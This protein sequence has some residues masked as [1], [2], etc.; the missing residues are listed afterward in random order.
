MNA[1]YSNAQKWFLGSTL[2]LVVFGELAYVLDSC[3]D[4]WMNE[5]KAL[6]PEAVISSMFL[7]KHLL[8]LILSIAVG[9]LLFTLIHYWKKR[10]AYPKRLSMVLGILLLLLNLF[11]W[12]AIYC[13]SEFDRD[14][15]PQDMD[16]HAELRYIRSKSHWFGRGDHYY[17]YPDTS[18]RPD[19]TVEEYQQMR[20]VSIRETEKAYYVFGQRSASLLPYL[21][22][23]YGKWVSGLY[24]LVA[25][26]W[27][28]GAVIGWKAVKGIWNRVLYGSCFLVLTAQVVGPLLEQLGI[29]IWPMPI[30]FSSMD[31]SYHI[32]C[33]VPLFA[34]MAFLVEGQAINE[35]PQSA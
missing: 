29:L 8:L 14:R 25:V 16:I 21:D 28:V 34:A 12:F 4:N 3:I 32:A 30:L 33:V 5:W 15:I 20:D 13:C 31:W 24:A 10:T 2:G 26:F 1:H 23:G 9:V 19:M 18:S 35:S 6:P 27:C 11:S 22:Y 7:R 17:T